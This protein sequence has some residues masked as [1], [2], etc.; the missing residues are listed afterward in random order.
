ML[1]NSGTE[2]VVRIYAGTPL[3]LLSSKMSSLWLRKSRLKTTVGIVQRKIGSFPQISPLNWNFVT[4]GPKEAFF[5]IV[6]YFAMTLA[7]SVPG[8]LWC[9]R[10]CRVMRSLPV[11]CLLLFVWIMYDLVS[12]ACYS[13][14]FSN[15]IDISSNSGLTKLKIKT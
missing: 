4:A 15:Q 3:H 2:G 5:A 14:T 8:L 12:Y 9:M 6:N 10:V 7:G 11:D 13:L 1:Q